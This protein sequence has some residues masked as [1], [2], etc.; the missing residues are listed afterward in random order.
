MPV[1]IL[2]LHDPLNKI[3]LKCLQMHI[4]SLICLTID[5]CFQLGLNVLKRLLKRSAILE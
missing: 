5:C 4:K 2:P 3:I 1:P